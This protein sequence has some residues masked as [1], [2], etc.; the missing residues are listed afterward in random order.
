MAQYFALGLARVGVKVD[1]VPLALDRLGYSPQFLALVDNAQPVADAPT[2]ACAWPREDFSRLPPTRD[3]VFY[4]M[5][6]SSRLAAG[7]E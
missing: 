2:L 4:T 1:V 5:W 7:M 6:E 3:S